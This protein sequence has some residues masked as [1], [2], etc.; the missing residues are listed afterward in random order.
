MLRRLT[1]VARAASL[2]L[3]VLSVSLIHGGCGGR[4]E[5]DDGPSAA[6]TSAGSV[7]GGRSCQRVVG[8]CDLGCVGELLE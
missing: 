8:T 5:L 3:G 1:V 6:G 2:A 7:G 4:T